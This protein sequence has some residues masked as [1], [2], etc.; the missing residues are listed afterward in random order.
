MEVD[1]NWDNFHNV[2]IRIA[3]KFGPKN[4][5]LKCTPLYR[6]LIMILGL[7]YGST[8]PCSK[9]TLLFLRIFVLRTK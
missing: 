4:E 9:N 3:H 6:T 7:V 5:H 1:T 2:Y 8:G